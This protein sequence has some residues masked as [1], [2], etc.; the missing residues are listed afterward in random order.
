MEGKCLL[1][2]DKP[3]HPC[4]G[5]SYDF[6]PLPHSQNSLNESTGWLKSLTNSVR[7]NKQ[8]LVIVSTTWP[9]QDSVTLTFNQDPELVKVRFVVKDVTVAAK[10]RYAKI[11]RISQQVL[12]CQLQHLV[13][14]KG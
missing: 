3:L 12:G 14:V 7:C 8:C 4:P 2:C 9:Q 6:L 11:S 5:G 1:T 10:L 13:P